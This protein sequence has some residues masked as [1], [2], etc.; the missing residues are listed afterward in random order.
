[1]KDRKQIEHTHKIDVLTLPDTIGINS[2]QLH[3]LQR[4]LKKNQSNDEPSIQTIRNWKKIKIKAETVLHAFVD[5]TQNQTEP[6][7]AFKSIYKQ[8]LQHAFDNNYASVV[9]EILAQNPA[10]ITELIIKKKDRNNAMAS[11][12]EASVYIKKKLDSDTIRA[13][14][15]GLS[16]V[17]SF[18][19]DK[20]HLQKLILDWENMNPSDIRL[21]MSDS[22]IEIL[23]HSLHKTYND[24]GKKGKRSCIC[25]WKHRNGQTSTLS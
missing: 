25:C 19:F 20:H 5:A 22:H 13:I 10:Q 4:A 21:F 2:L 15:F 12:S 23:D 14:S 24:E 6:H 3:I 9:G 8:M 16:E 18:C 1:M 17:V 11:N 7:N